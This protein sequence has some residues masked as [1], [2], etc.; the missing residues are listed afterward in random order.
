MPALSSLRTNPLRPRLKY[1]DAFTNGVTRIIQGAEAHVERQQDTIIKQRVTKPY[2]HDELD[3]RIRERRTQTEAN[4]LQKL[5]FTPGLIDTEDTTLRMEYVDGDL[6]KERLESTPSVMQAVGETVMKMHDRDI[7]H[8]DLTTS[9]IIIDDEPVIIDF[10]LGGHT[11]RAEDK[12]VDL[13]LLHKSIESKHPGVAQTAWDHF[14][15]AYNP[16][17]KQGILERFDEVKQ[18]G[19]YK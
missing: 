14:Q 12:A 13:Y 1:K 9:N 19:R 17:N 18:R 16:A 3:Q 15:T 10:G 5:S 2:R 6:L 4:L 8:G 11:D 7:Y